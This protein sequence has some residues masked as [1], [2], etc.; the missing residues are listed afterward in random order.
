M[1]GFTFTYTEIQHNK[2]TSPF[3][4]VEVS[5][6]VVLLSTTNVVTGLIIINGQF[7]S[8]D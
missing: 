3:I 1:W 8:K 4:H 6:I 5:K 7:L 2:R